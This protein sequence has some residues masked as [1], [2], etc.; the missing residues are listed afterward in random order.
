MSETPSQELIDFILHGSEERNLEYKESMSWRQRDAKVEITRCILGM[1]NLR[2]GGT[3]VLGVKEDDNDFVPIGMQTEHAKSFSHDKVA[4]YVNER[5][6]PFVEIEVTIVSHEGKEFV[7]IQI[8]EFDELPVI[9]K[10]EGKLSTGDL[11][12]R[13]GA[14]YIRSRRMCET[15]EVPSQTEMR[16]IIELAVDKGVRRLMERM[17]RTGIL[18]LVMEASDSERFD[19]QLGELK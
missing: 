14:M 4:P 9:C 5:A 15:I 11:R 7:V 1:A 10:R 18:N 13:K 19:E 2:D 6:D 16:E 8:R 12:L 17:S 3:I